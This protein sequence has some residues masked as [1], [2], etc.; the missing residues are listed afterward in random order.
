MLVTV[1]LADQSRNKK[2][3]TYDPYGRLTGKLVL[4]DNGGIN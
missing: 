1:A 4:M 2:E 3:V